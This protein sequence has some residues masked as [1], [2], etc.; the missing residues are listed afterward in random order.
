MIDT[1]AHIITRYVFWIHRTMYKSICLWLILAFLKREKML[2]Y[3]VIKVNLDFLL[4]WQLFWTKHVNV[5]IR[6]KIFR[7]NI[8]YLQCRY[9]LVLFH[10]HLLVFKILTNFIVKTGFVLNRGYIC[11][12]SIQLFFLFSLQCTLQFH[13]FKSKRFV[14]SLLL[15]L[16]NS[17]SMP[18]FPE[19]FHTDIC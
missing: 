7:F 11:R 19:T 2:T 16:L 3:D 15:G 4:P 8:A 14:L 17:S 18:Y 10:L 6:L 12:F 5:T 1:S 9:Q 13:L